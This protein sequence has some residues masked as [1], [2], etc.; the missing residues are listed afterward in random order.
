[1]KIS[2]RR[3][4]FLTLSSLIL[5]AASQVARA[6]TVTYFGPDNGV[7]SAPANW[8][9]AAVP[10]INDDVFLGSHNLAIN[11]LHVTFNETVATG[12]NSVTLN[13][14]GIGGFMIVNQT[15]STSKLLTSTLNIGTTVISN[16]WNQS[17][18]TV[19]FFTMNLGVN[20]AST[21]NSYNLSGTGSITHGAFVGST[22]SENIGVSGAGVFNQTGGTH[23]GNG[24][25]LTLGVNVGSSG[26]YNLSAGTL[27]G[28]NSLKIAQSGA[29]LF[30]QTGGAISSGPI[31]VGTGF[32]AGTYNMSGGTVNATGSS[33]KSGITLGGL[34][35]ATFNL[36][37]GTVTAPSSTD[38]MGQ[39]VSGLAIKNGG[40]FNLQFGGTLNADVGIG[41]GGI[42]NLQGGVFGSAP[43]LTLTGG[44]F[45]LIGHSLTVDSIGG[46]GGVVENTGGNAVLTLNLAS[47]SASYGGT[48]QDGGAGALSLVLNGSGSQ[49]T[50]GGANIHT[51]STTITAGSLL[52]GSNQG[53]SSASAFL[54]NGG[55]LKAN[56]FDVTI[57]SLSGTGGIVDVGSGSLTTG[58]NGGSTS[59][60]GQLF[61]T[62]AFNKLGAGQ[63][64]LSGSGSSTF[65]TG[66][67]NVQGGSLRVGAVDGIAPGAIVNLIGSTSLNVNFNQ[68]LTGLTGGNLANVN[69]A[70]NSTLNINPAP[71]SFTYAGTFTGGGTLLK[72]GTAGSTL[73]LGNGAADTV[74]NTDTSLAIGVQ[75]GTLALNKADGTNAVGAA[76]SVSAGTLLLQRGNQIPDT[77]PLT[78]NGGTFN[79]AGFSETIGNLSGAGGGIS[80][81][82]GSLTVTQTTAN[83]Y[84]GA[85][86]GT[87]AFIKMGAADLTLTSVGAFGGGFTASVGRLVLQGPIGGASFDALNGGTLRFTNA[88]ANLNGNTV[89]AFLGGNAEYLGATVSNGTLA[90]PGT[91]TVLTGGGASTFTN[92]ATYNSTVLTQNGAATFTNFTNGGTLNNNLAATLNRGENTSSGV[93]NVTSTLNTKDFTSNGVINVAVGGII[94]NTVANFVLGGGSRTFIGTV[95][96]PGGALTTAVGTS[97]ELNGGL[98]VN[99]GTQTG[100][101]NVN[102]GS[103]AKGAGTFGTV[104]VTDGG[105]FSPGNS[106]GTATVSGMTF[107]AGGSYQFELNSAN[108]TPGNGADFIDNLGTLSIT[109]GTTANS[110]FSIA[111]LS[112]SAANQ[113]SAL[114]DFDAGLPHS[115]TLVTAAGGITGFAANE[116]AVDTTGFANNL[117]GGFFSVAQS[118]NDLLLNFTPVPEP[119]TCVLLLGGLG[120]LGLRRTRRASAT[121]H[122]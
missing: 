13:S 48:I 40:V 42:F 71:A 98:L 92:V 93:M 75:N 60:N 81:G 117:R 32:S 74:A 11:D 97:I 102:Y 76:V 20:A 107:A 23:D 106:P 115:F 36:S 9:P 113:P 72:S 55:S 27:S 29:G 95:A 43:I 66:N 15:S 79:L 68:T 120:L 69:F 87:G 3:L 41:I 17:A 96:A 35:N 49:Q 19:S 12:Y 51:G 114:T 64:T 111:V 89:Q 26:T 18:G 38:S 33:I 94:S 80:L 53:F 30:T 21:G 78:I 63:L 70:A 7:W 31:E 90:G 14:T 65:F 34:A 56:G 28:F 86:A 108:A 2:A 59:Y 100:T 85:V 57:L 84:N 10:A 103:V 61:G 22:S 88:T 121:K 118:G 50:L 46:T 4:R 54:V 83:N 119:T 112:L 45:R 110:V 52:A 58:S 5:A 67:I 99:N 82:G 109:A 47:G 6:T 62:G 44:S 24:G 101:L 39:P 104:N 25:N 77:S 8:N 122:S 1:M 37:G 91:H 16:T 116:F 73:I 105:R